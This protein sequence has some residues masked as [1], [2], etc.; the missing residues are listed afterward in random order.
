M[1]ADETRAAARH[2]SEPIGMSDVLV[3]AIAER[4]RVAEDQ[5]LMFPCRTARARIRLDGGRGRG[6]FRPPKWMVNA[7]SGS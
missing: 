7:D 6:L 3:R 1:E 4:A 2:G 5:P